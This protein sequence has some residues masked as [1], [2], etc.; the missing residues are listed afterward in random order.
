MNIGI[1]LGLAANITPAKK[2]LSI[3]EHTQPMKQWF[4]PLPQINCGYQEAA[5]S[6]Y[7][8][9]GNRDDRV[10]LTLC[11]RITKSRLWETTEQMVGLKKE[12]GKGGGGEGR[13][14]R[15]QE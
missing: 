14:G 7:Q 9:I 5:R 3:K 1:E 2:C 10:T 13:Q 4:F 8:F 15:E 11:G 12:E 6:N